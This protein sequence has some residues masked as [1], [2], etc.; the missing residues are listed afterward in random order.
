MT[1]YPPVS[2]FL[3][4]CGKCQLELDGGELAEEPRGLPPAHVGVN[5]GPITYTDGDYYGL[6]SSSPR[7]SPRRPAPVRFWSARRSQEK[8]LRPA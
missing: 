4:D 2:V 6:S 3:G 5:A 7:G 1:V 8:K